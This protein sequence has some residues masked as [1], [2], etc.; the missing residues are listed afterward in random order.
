MT[1]TELELQR[2]ARKDPLDINERLAQLTQESAALAT[3]RA[4]AEREAATYIAQT[5]ALAHRISTIQVATT[6]LAGLPALAPEQEWLA[7]LTA[8]RKA[9]CDELLALPARIRDKAGLHRQENL[10]FSIRLIDF[11]LRVVSFG[12][13]VDLSPLRIGEL[14][15][16]AGYATSGPELQGSHGWLGSN[17]EVEGRIRNITRQRAAAQAQLDEA[18]MDDDARA[19]ADAEGAACRETLRT[20]DIKNNEDPNVPGLVAYT[21]DGDVLTLPEMTAAQRQAFEWFSRSFAPDVAATV[22]C[23]SDD[24][25]S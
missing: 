17:S 23:P 16:E 6:T 15:A 12:P 7:H 11:G 10:T 13:V 22:A 5:G 21:Q 24:A 20:M 25:T 18:L 2:A 14:M 1:I 8:W 4:R 19:K 3:S 9:L